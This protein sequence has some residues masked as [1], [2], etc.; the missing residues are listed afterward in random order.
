MKSVPACA[1]IVALVVVGHAFAADP[2]TPAVL[3]GSLATTCDELR[4]EFKKAPAPEVPSDK[5]AQAAPTPQ[6]VKA[7]REALVSISTKAF[8][9]DVTKLI[10]KQHEQLRT[11]FANDSKTIQRLHIVLGGRKGELEQVV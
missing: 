11:S 9:D 2:P 4:K 8:A 5:C 1:M 10:D 7:C 3:S 6:D